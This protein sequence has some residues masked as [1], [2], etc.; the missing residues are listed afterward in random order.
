MG[1][2]PP[3]FRNGTNMEGKSVSGRVLDTNIF[4]ATLN[5]NVNYLQFN[6]RY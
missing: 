3:G 5:V 4:R 6:E 1:G 2:A